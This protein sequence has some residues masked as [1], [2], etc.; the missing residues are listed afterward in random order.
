VLITEQLFLY[1]LGFIALFRFGGVHSVE[2]HHDDA[3]GLMTENRLLFMT[4]E[5]TYIPYICLAF[6]PLS[7]DN[8]QE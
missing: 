6:W 3:F 1:Q 8:K 4:D 2:T 5:V 7:L